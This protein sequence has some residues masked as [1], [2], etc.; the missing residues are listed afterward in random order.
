MKNECLEIAKDIFAFKNYEIV[1][2][3]FVIFYDC[4]LKL[5]IHEHE[6]DSWFSAAVIDLSCNAL[7][8]INEDGEDDEAWYLYQADDVWEEFEF[9]GLI[10][11]DG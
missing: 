3:E 10:P 5:N 8:L 6:K 11:E 9:L 7:K 2:D 1:D 4:R